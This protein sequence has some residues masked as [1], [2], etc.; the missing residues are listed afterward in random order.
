[1]LMDG[2]FDIDASIVIDVE[3]TSI[4]GQGKNTII[5]SDTAISLISN[6]SKHG[7]SIDNI[8]FINATA[9]GSICVD[10]FGADNCKI[11]NCWFDQY[12]TGIQDRSGEYGTYYGNYFEDGHTGIYLWSALFTSV[13]SNTFEG[14]TSKAI[15]IFGQW[16]SITGNSIEGSSQGIYIAAHSY[17]FL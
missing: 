15:N 13:V 14:A 9:S 8:Y 4:R 11:Y 3:N 1:M 7:M 2:T 12:R 5:L 10:M 6:T 17:Y 16:N